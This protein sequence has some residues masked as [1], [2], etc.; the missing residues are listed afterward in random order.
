[1]SAPFIGEIRMA[2]FSYAPQPGWALCDGRVLAI[3]QNP[4]LFALIG[5]T[6]GGDGQN[7][8]ALPDLRSRVPV[9]EGSAPGLSSYLLGQR[10]G[11]ESVTLSYASLPSH[12]HALNVSSAD[13]TLPTP[14]GEF[15]AKP[16][17]KLGNADMQDFASAPNSIMNPTAVSGIPNSGQAHPNLQPYLCVNFIIALEGIFPSRN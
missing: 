4:A 2:G 15:L 5:I 1:M 6:Y 7:T 14:V 9:N 13:G 3:S 11:I 17:D 10:S 8:F 12:S 16:I